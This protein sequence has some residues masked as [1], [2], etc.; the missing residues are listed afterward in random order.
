MDLL[1]PLGSI[2]SHSMF[3][4]FGLFS[5]KTVFA[6]VAEQRLCIR[7]NESQKKCLK[8][9]DFSPFLYKTDGSGCHLL[10]HP[11]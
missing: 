3:G 9:V 6:F 5:D 2:T 4:G 8:S 10:L 11:T 7:A 1:S